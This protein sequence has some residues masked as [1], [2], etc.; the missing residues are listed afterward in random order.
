MSII[1]EALEKA[2][3]SEQ[4]TADLSRGNA[5][6]RNPKPKSR[7]IFPFLRRF[8]VILLALSFIPLAYFLWHNPAK[9]PTPPPPEEPVH[10][11]PIVSVE[12]VEEPLQIPVLPITVKE[13]GFPLKTIKL[14]G[15]MHAPEKPLAVINGSIWGEGEYIEKFKILEIGKDFLRLEKDGRVFTVRLKR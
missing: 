8:L 2:Q 12:T 13:E 9:N 4:K 6:L 7:A 1:A 10:E 11:E 3:K 5:P 15:I 14:T